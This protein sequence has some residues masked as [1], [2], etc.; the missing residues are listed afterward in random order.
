VGGIGGWADGVALLRWF[1]RAVIRLVGGWLRVW[2]GRSGGLSK[3]MK[4]GCVQGAGEVRVGV[5]WGWVAWA[6]GLRGVGPVAVSDRGLGM[7]P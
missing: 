6:G 3:G 1:C 7:G 5:G 2:A 4:L